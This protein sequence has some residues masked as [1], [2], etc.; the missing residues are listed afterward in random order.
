MYW[1]TILDDE[2][3]KAGISKQPDIL[4]PEQARLLDILKGAELTEVDKPIALAWRDIVQRLQQLPYVTSEWMLYFTKHME[5]YFQAVRWEVLNYSQGIMPDIA[6][7]IKMRH[8]LFGI[9]PFLDMIL[10]ADGIALP[11]EVLECPVVKRMGLAANNAMAWANDIFSFK[12]DIKEGMVHN[13]VL[14]LHYEYHISLEE[15]LKRA[16]E[17]HDAQVRNFIELSVKLPSFG[18]EIDVNLQRYVLALRFWM[19][20]HLDWIMESRRYGKFSEYQSL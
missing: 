4:E 13:L 11:L 5:D 16:V 9:Y 8:I 10:I 7:Y 6:T 17:F 12:R 3:E 15:A 19:S 14:I 1:G 2:F 18:S 20:G